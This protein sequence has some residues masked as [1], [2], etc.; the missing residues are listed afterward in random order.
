[1]NCYNTLFVGRLAYE[2]SERKLL[3]ELE[4]FGP[5]KDLKLVM[6]KK[7]LDTGGA[8]GMGMGMGIG[9]SSS[10]SENKSRG[11]AFVEF[12]NMEDMKRAYRGADG[13]RLDG[14]EIVVDVE[15]GHTV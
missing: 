9:S 8:D 5:V 13:M 7:P 1:M 6:M 14:R 11:Y 10:T 15:R 4:T 12:E 2:T 3:R